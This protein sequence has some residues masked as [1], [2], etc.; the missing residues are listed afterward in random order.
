[1]IMK[2]RI[3]IAALVL[4]AAVLVVSAAA[5]E[6]TREIRKGDRV[7]IGTFPQTAEGTDRTPIEWVVLAVQDGKG[8][9]MSK[10][11]LI[12]MA[13]HTEDTDVTWEACAL[14]AWLNNEFYRD[15]FS[16]EEKTAI[17]LTDV[18]NST[19]QRYGKWRKPKEPDTQDYVY[20]LSYAEAHK[21]LGME[22]DVYGRKSRI[23][24]TDYAVK[25]GA[26]VE[27]SI[28]T[29]EGKRTGWWMLRS[30]G[31]RK[32]GASCVNNGGGLSDCNVT[33]A[34]GCICPVLWADLSSPA[35]KREA[36]AA[37]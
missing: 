22:K 20:L 1:M 29:A 28:R 14:R 17:L 19:A 21:Y 11:G 27:E 26:H 16:E 34:S 3:R 6:E 9:L 5:G 32:H 8:F 2:K 33:L 31:G 15:A 37:E 36:P 18:D 12:A 13:Y 30:P 4:L 10:R 25:T 35:L 24:P 23:E 7:F